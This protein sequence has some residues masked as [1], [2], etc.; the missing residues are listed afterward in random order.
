MLRE[1]KINDSFQPELDPKRYGFQE[2][3]RVRFSGILGLNKE[4]G[5][6]AEATDFLK[7]T[8]AKALSAEFCYADVSLTISAKT[9]SHR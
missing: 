1:L 6:I 7:K 3:D 8:Y 4:E 5:T 2:T 9:T